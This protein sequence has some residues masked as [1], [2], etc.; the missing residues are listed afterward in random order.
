MTIKVREKKTLFIEC[1][2]IDEA[3]ENI[4]LKN[5]DLI[6]KIQFYNIIEILNKTRYGKNILLECVIKI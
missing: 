3:I 4:E 6:K 2:T 1:E 5:S